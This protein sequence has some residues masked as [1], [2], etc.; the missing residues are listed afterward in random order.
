MHGLTLGNLANGFLVHEKIEV[1][2]WKD[3][4]CHHLL[5]IKE[6]IV[7]PIVLILKC[8]V[9]SCNSSDKVFWVPITMIMCIFWIG[10]GSF[11]VVELITIIGE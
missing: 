9:P 2:K 11:I 4:L 3:R 6:I 7:W 5:S 8:T 1:P 10:M